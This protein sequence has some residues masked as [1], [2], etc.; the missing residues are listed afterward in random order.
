MSNFSLERHILSMVC[1]A[2]DAYSAVLFLPDADVEGCR[3]Q[4]SFS[5]GDDIAKDSV[6]LAGKGL[7]GWIIRNQQPLIVDNF[8]QHTRL[9]Y[10]KNDEEAHIKAFIGCPLSSGGALCVDSKRQYSFTPKDYKL[11][12][13]FAEMISQLQVRQGRQESMVD[14]PRYFAELGV[15]HDLR[16]QYKRWS[17]YIRNFLQT[18]LN[19]VGFE[20]AAFASVHEPG[21]SYLVESESSDLLL[22]GD[23]PLVLPMGSGIAGWVFRNDQPVIAEGME[24][25]PAAVLFGKLPDM[26]DFQAVMCLPILINKSTRA[27]LCLAQTSPRQ[28]DETLRSF[29]NQAVDSLSLYL[30]NLYLRTRLRNLLPQAEVHADIRA[31]APHREV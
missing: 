27:V 2:F 18:T 25:A 31:D 20:Y 17:Q 30:E 9:G 6:I 24:G 8:D 13:L 26:P 7:V 10:Y 1:T 21:V 3:L 12:Q 22:T 5:L 4:E 11:L 14:I 16:A 28:I 29:V 15:I 23:A 19:A